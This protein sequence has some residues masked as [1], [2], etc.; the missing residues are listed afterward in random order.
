MSLHLFCE[1]LQSLAPSMMI[2]E[3]PWIFPALETAHV[4]ALVMVIGTISMIDLRLLGAYARER[5]V[6]V[7]TREMLPVTWAAF[8]TAAVTGALMFSSSA[9]T[10]VDNLPFRFKMLVLL[11]AA[12]NMLA[13]H[14][15]AYRSV[16]RWHLDP[17]PPATAKLAGG[18]S[19]A[20]WL[21]IV[22][23]GRW[24]GFV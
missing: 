9:T 13:F 16:D 22:T 15:A 18:L 2:A 8:A 5:S 11:V 7:M 4:L 12:A 23:L 20:C 6:I 1:W 10:Y 3:S 14:L 17:R 19:L 24:I 21:T